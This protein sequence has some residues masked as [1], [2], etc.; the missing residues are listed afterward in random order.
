MRRLI[1][2]R[3]QFAVRGC[4]RNTIDV[5]PDCRPRSLPAFRVVIDYPVEQFDRAIQARRI[6]NVG[7][8]EQK[9]RPLAGRRQVVA[10]KRIDVSR[11]FHGE[12]RC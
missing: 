10:G 7:I 8:V 4:M 9:L 11:R 6:S 5:R 2:A 3:A 1:H 12:L